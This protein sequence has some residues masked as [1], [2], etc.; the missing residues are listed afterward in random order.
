MATCK[1]QVQDA[2]HLESMFA[3]VPDSPS[4]LVCVAESPSVFQRM[5][6]LSFCDQQDQP[7]DHFSKV[8]HHSKSR[9]L[10]ACQKLQT[11]TLYEADPC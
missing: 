2:G 11:W 9:S 10:L 5:M 4:V 3:C 6:H 8:F 1:H 7:F